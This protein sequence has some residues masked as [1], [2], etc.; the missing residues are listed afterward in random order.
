MP[1]M[2]YS[3]IS[4]STNQK[5]TVA[6]QLTMV[7]IPLPLK[8]SSILYQFIGINEG[9]Y[10]NRKNSAKNCIKNVCSEIIKLVHK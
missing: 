2:I 7:I 5:G 6:Q 3:K 9:R 1:V 8:S 4:K 10:G